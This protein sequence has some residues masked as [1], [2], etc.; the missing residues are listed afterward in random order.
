MKFLKDLY[1]EFING[2]ASEKLSIISNLL[3]VLTVFIAVIFSPKI[4]SL[5][6]GINTDAYYGMVFA[7]T[8]SI[9]I[10]LIS[11]I[12]VIASFGLKKFLWTNAPIWSKLFFV[13]LNVIIWGIVLA[14]VPPLISFVYSMVIR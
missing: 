11:I 7:T 6:Y 4:L 9:V 10:V 5:I 1:N 3:Q 13:T 14:N 8:F 2:N 12:I